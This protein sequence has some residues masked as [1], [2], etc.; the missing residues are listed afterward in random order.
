MRITV[1]GLPG[2]GKSTLARI[3]AEKLS[4]PHIHIDRFWFEAGGRKGSYDTPDIEGVRAHVREKVI[5]AIRA[6]Q[7]V[8]DGFY[9]RVQPDIAN[10]ADTVIFLDIPLWRRLLN[11]ATRLFRRS[12]RHGE[13]SIFDDLTFFAEIIRREFTR[14]PRLRK[15]VSQYKNK[16]VTL[17]SRKQITQYVES[18]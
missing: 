1:I 9:S 6:D 15:F 17:K 14:L 13:V 8:S 16:T 18:L 7:W 10:R 12:S 5:S 11:H 4:I 2:S 3:I